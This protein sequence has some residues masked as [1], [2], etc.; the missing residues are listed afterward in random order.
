[1][2]GRTDT[3]NRIE[4]VNIAPQIDFLAE[5]EMRRCSARDR[6]PLVSIMMLRLPWTSTLPFPVSIGAERGLI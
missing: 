1:M 2:V 4:L 5:R 3:G 6:A